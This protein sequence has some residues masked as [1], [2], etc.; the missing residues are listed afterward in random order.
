MLVRDGNIL[1]QTSSIHDDGIHV[2]MG[3][4]EPSEVVFSRACKNFFKSK[5]MLKKRIRCFCNSYFELM[6]MYL[7][8]INRNFFKFC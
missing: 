5:L 6:K 4:C 7:L 2:Q 1:V 3:V 8:F